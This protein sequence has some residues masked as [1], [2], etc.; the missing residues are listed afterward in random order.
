[1]KR[2]YTLLIFLLFCFAI[3]LNG[4]GQNNFVTFETTN[5]SNKICQDK[6]L[7]VIATLAPEYEGYKSFEWNGDSEN[8][9]EVKDEIA[10]VN[11]S[12]PGEKRLKFTLSIDEKQK[13]ETVFVVNVLPKP[14]VEVSYT[15]KKLGF[16]EISSSKIASYKWVFNNTI[17]PENTKR[18]IDNPQLGKYRVV[19]TDSNGCITTSQEII[20]E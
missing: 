8:F 16:S 7:G 18:I 14:Q 4:Y 17:L 15:N 10:I 3:S 1:M 11:S 9:K 12:T 13:Y 19:V 5:Q 6:T 20:V 2:T